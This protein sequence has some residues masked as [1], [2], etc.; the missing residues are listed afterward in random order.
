M[1]ME[2]ESYQ[3]SHGYLN[4][5]FEGMKN[6]MDL[7]KGVLESPSP[8]KNYGSWNLCA[9]NAQQ[10]ENNFPAV[11]VKNGYKSYSAK[12]KKVPILFDMNMT[13]KKGTIYSLLGSSGC[14]KTT[15]LNCIVHLQNLVGI[16]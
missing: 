6:I 3:K 14:G 5:A 16:F 13:V 2:Q 4:S 10:M 15:L 7:Q 9:F 1:R 11:E 8:Y 12:G